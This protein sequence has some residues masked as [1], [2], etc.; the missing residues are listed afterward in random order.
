MKMIRTLAT[1]L[2]AAILSASVSVAATADPVVKGPGWT[3][4]TA[5]GKTFTR[6][7]GKMAP[8]HRPVRRQ[9]CARVD[10]G[11]PRR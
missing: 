2:A 6:I 4:Y 10:L 5:T 1:W 3:G 8:A 7:S 11:G 9:R